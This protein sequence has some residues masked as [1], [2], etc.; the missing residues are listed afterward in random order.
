M[1]IEQFV[2][3]GF[4][5]VNEA[6]DGLRDRR[7][8]KL[9]PIIENPGGGDG[10]ECGGLRF[11][12]RARGGD[13]ERGRGFG[14]GDELL[15]R[16]SGDNAALIDD[17]NLVAEAVGFFDVMRGQQ[18]SAAGGFELEDQVV[19]FAAGLG[20]EAG[21]GFVEEN[22]LRIVHEREGQGEALALA[23][24]E[25]VKGGVG[26]VGEVEL[27]EQGGRVGGMR[28]EGGEEAEG[29]AR[30]DFVLQGGGLE[31]H[32]DDFAGLGGMFERVDAGHLDHAGVQGGTQADDAFEGGGFSR[33]RWGPAGRRL[34]RLATSNETSR[35]ACSGP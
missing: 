5:E 27:L 35:T 25:G 11:C 14:G 7:R 20:V 8:G 6:E 9:P 18:N 22:D 33:A 28:I 10:G 24:G 3:F 17:C 2:F 4:D 30:G 34:R 16:A 32:A 15:G 19:Q 31:L 23:A 21:G 13:G 12:Q 26:F 29:L 1:Q